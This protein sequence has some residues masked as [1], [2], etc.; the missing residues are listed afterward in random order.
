MADISAQD[1]AG[2][3]QGVPSTNTPISGKDLFDAA[4]SAP[5][6]SGMSW[7]QALIQGGASF[8]GG[9]IQLGKNSYAAVTHPFETA[10]TVMDIGAGMLRN[11]EPKQV[12]DWIDQL[13]WNPQMSKQN[14]SLA[15][16]V[17]QFYKDRFGSSEG[18]KKAV[19]TDPVG[20]MSDISAVLSGGAGAV[21]LIGDLSKSAKIAQAAE[22]LGAA[23][24]YTNPLLLAAGT[25]GT[26]AKQGLGLTTGAGSEAIANAFKAGQAGDSSF[27]AALRGQMPWDAPLQAAK[28]NL[29]IM[30]Q[31][32]A[33]AY[34]SGMIDVTNDK[35]VLDFNDIDQAIQK[36]FG[37]VSYKGQIKDPNAAQVVQDI[38]NRVSAWK[39][40]N[41]AD[42]HTPEGMDA[43]KQNI[44]S[45]VE[46]IPF[47]QKNA[48]RV[49]GEIYNSIKN[50]ISDQAP[51]YS[52]VMSDY[53]EASD[54]IG[55][56]EK[57]L[58]LGSKASSDTAMRKLLSLT[59]NNVN[60]NY[61]N[62]LSLAQQL[63]Q[64]G[65]K[66]FINALS[67]MALSS[68][69]ARGM[70]GTGETASILAAATN[71]A[72]LGMIPFQ[73]PRIVGEGAYLAG[74]ASAPVSK[75]S[76]ITGI[77]PTSGNMLLDI[78]KAQP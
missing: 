23:A 40:L 59:R 38:N 43:L 56:I 57:A 16:Q 8:P 39:N 13:D 32:R 3:V 31:N 74:R 76:D 41:P 58:S 6:D 2:L 34:R 26:V 47:E 60:T 18:F 7:P 20:V 5:Q 25:A 14:S 62:R 1:L 48:R 37:S 4:S 63:E 66:P 42:Y 55:E 17:A 12:A 72:Y 15:T 36:S 75:L 73:T 28:D 53:S 9:V 24:K 67:G 21:G 45:V 65:G 33:N 54:Q 19:A 46:G 29:E 30:R 77:N 22:S 64:E 52:K 78:M 71:P 70:A 27:L 69:T 49:A 11:L 68:G 10:K 61:G 44:G 35:S 50:T 51:T